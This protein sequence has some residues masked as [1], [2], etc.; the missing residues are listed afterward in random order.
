M[1]ISRAAGLLAL[2]SGAFAYKALSDDGLRNIA[3]PAND[4]DIKQGALLAPILQPRVP[5]TPGSTAVL[6]HFV[7]FFRKELPAWH[8][9]FQNS[10]SKTPISGD[11]ETPFVNLIA[12]RDP[13]WAEQGHV[14]RLALVAHYDSKIDPPGFIGAIDSAAPC[15]MLMHA[16]R[17]L[18]DALTNKW[19]AMEA[20]GDNELDEA[21][22]IQ[23]LLLDGEEAFKVWTHDDSIYGAR[24]LAEEWE[25]TMHPA[26][27]IYRT[28]LDAIDLFVLLDL[29]GSANPRVPSFFRTTHWAY[30]NMANAETRLRSLKQLQ[31]TPASPFLREANKKESDRW[32][33]GAIE[34]DHI[35]FQARGVD[36][37]HMI[38][39]PFPT[40]WHTMADDGEHLDIPTVKDWAKIVTAF[41]AEWMELD[42]YLL[43]PKKRSP[44]PGTD[45]TEL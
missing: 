3:D 38:P 30:L 2:L 27:S 14:G 23:I 20:E 24:S 1:I 32:L 34:D 44:P 22:G 28:P 15:A 8:L 45:R 5:G 11:Q 42:G 4:F 6:N 18:D 37:L 9:T 13:P 7:D 12:T 35:P 21:S 31:T 29:L 25:Q 41:A 26:T 43:P 16:A 39:A 36:I 17:S 10:S 33:G 19:A 40:V